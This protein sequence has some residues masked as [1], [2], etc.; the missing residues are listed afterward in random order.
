MGP[1][2]LPGACSSMGFPQGHSLLRASTCSG[3][4]SSTGCR[5]ISAPLQTL[6]GLQGHSLPHHGLHHGLQGNLCS[7]TWSTSSPSFFPDL[8]VCRVVSLTSSHPSL[9]LQLLLRRN[10]FPF[11]NMLSQRHYCCPKNQDS[12]TRCAKKPMNTQ[13]S[14]D[15]FFSCLRRDGC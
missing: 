10:F 6:H 1:Q 15:L 3:V 14:R 11:L 5:W 2:V 7:G 4:G 12:F 8:G 9:Q 13:E